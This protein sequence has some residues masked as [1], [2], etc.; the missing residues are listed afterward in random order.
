MKDNVDKV[1]N[2][3]EELSEAEFRACKKFWLFCV[4]SLL[5]INV[6]LLDNKGIDPQIKDWFQ[7]L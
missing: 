7:N 6:Y 5:K 4:F 2:R 1:L 3:E